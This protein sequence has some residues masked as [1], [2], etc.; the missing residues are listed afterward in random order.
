MTFKNSFLTKLINFI[1]TAFYM[2]GFLFLITVVF[3]NRFQF[4]DPS[5]SKQ[6]L[7]PFLIMLFSWLFICILQIFEIFSSQNKQQ[8]TSEFLR[9]NIIFILF[10]GGHYLWNIGAQLFMLN[11]IIIFSIGIFTFLI[12]SQNMIQYINNTSI[13]D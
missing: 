10:L 7:M 12:C 13:H 11:N 3:F 8:L 1:S 4:N 6:Y 5:D 2:M 9:H